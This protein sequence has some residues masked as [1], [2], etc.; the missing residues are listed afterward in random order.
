MKI[1]KTKK[2]GYSTKTQVEYQRDGY[3][4]RDD[5]GFTPFF[6]NET[7]GNK[8]MKVLIACGVTLEQMRD[9][10]WTVEQI[11]PHAYTVDGVHP[12]AARIRITKPVIVIH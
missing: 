4:S 12:V 2:T 6:I 9:Y 11:G 8:F 10:T 1:F 5:K 7:A 3:S